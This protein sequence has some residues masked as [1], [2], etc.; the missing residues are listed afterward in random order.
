MFSESQLRRLLQS[1]IAY[2]NRSRCHTKAVPSVLAKSTPME[3]S[4]GTGD[5]EALVSVVRALGEEDEA[6]RLE[7]RVRAIRE[8]NASDE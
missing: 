8:A 4:G 2:Y 7:A 3:F 1:Y 5:L 6:A